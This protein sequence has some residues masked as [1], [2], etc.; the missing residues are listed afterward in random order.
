MDTVGTETSAANSEL[1]GVFQVDEVRVKSFLEEKMRGTIEEMMNKL[2]DA[3]CQAERYQRS[4]DRVTTRSGSYQRKLH[5]T[6]GEVNLKMPRL[7]AFPFETQIIERYSRRQSS[8]EE[9]LMEMFLA[10]L[11]VRRVEDITEALWG[12]RVKPGVVCD[13][14]QKVRP[15]LY[16]N[17]ANGL[18]LEENEKLAAQRE[19]EMAANLIIQQL[20]SLPLRGASSERPFRILFRGVFSAAVLAYWEKQLKLTQPGVRIADHFDLIADTSTGGILAI[21]LGLGMSAADPQAF[22][23]NNGKDIFG[24]GE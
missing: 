13:L 22:Y 4:A 10:G 8:V 6:V 23:V 9:S 18:A 11:S 14:N 2:L 3:L 19:P 15:D 16:Y 20:Q 5:T 24:S 21:G 1:K 12:L 17:C 7:R